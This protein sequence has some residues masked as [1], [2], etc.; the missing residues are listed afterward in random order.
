MFARDV[1]VLLECQPA[2]QRL[3]GAAARAA[4]KRGAK[5]RRQKTQ[6]VVRLLNA[7][8]DSGASTTVSAT[9]QMSVE[10]TG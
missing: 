8:I 6:S 3:S 1:S 5:S 2:P 7:R 10:A 9:D 4:A